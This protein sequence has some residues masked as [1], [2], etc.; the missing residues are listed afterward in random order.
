MALR[1]VAAQHTQAGLQRLMH[2]AQSGARYW[3]HRLCFSS[4]SAVVL[5]HVVHVWHACMACLCRRILAPVFHFLPFCLLS[6][7]H[8]PATHCAVYRA[9]VYQV[10]RILYC[11]GHF[12]D[13]SSVSL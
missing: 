5:K 2:N 13:C 6:G 9:G 11:E 10:W 4:N 7:A 12:T 8:V 1:S 3:S